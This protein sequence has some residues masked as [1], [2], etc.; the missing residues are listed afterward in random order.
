[1]AHSEEEIEMPDSGSPGFSP[2]KNV[3]AERDERDEA[4]DALF[5]AK[6]RETE[7]SAS[8]SDTPTA[9]TSQAEASSHRSSLSLNSNHYG[10][11]SQGE[12]AQKRDEESI[13]KTKGESNCR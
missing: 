11:T 9:S 3:R 2:R 4:L 5:T 1:M 8:P 13:R 12:N 6:K 10:S 7:P